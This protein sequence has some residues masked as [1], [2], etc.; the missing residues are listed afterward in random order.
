ACAEKYEDMGTN[1]F[2]TGLVER[3]EKTAWMLRAMLEG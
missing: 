3:H 2:L 1:D